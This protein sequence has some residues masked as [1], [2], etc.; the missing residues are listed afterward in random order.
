[1]ESPERAAIVALPPLT[2]VTCPSSLT[3]TTS[4]LLLDH[5]TVRLV[6]FSGSTVAVRGSLAFRSIVRRVLSSRIPE[7]GITTVTLHE[8]LTSL[9]ADVAVIMA[10]PSDAAVTWPFVPTVAT[11]GSLLVHTSALSVASEGRI[12]AI[13][14]IRAPTLSVISA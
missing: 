6:A 7:T 11:S 13:R 12:V 1:M 14:D 5:V 2:P 3:V 4:G 10:L 9:E 8:T